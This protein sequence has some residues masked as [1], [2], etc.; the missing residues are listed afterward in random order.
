[1][2]KAIQTKNSKVTHQDF[3]V[4]DDRDSLPE[5]T[6]SEEQLEAAHKEVF[7]EEDE[8]KIVSIMDFCDS[9]WSH[10]FEQFSP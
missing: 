8:I 4:A 2:K 7:G 1:M 9:D 6:V 5:I 10:K 3:G